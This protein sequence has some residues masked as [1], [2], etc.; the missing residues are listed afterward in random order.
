METVRFYQRQGLLHTPKREGGIRRYGS[1]DLRRLRFI[2]QAQA[3]GFTLAQIKEL[4]GLDA[5]ENRSRALELASARIDA[6][7]EKIAE[8]TKARNA[9]Q[10]LAQECGAGGKG[11]CP[12]LTSFDI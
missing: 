1:D 8:L 10:R 11:L 6:L 7:N 9:L 4:L 2:K 12:I 3:A 5:S